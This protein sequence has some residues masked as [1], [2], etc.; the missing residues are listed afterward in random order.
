MRSRFVYFIKPIGMD[1]P[2]KIGCSD[3][4]VRRLL[5]LSVWSPF[6]LEVIAV[7]PGDLGT[8]KR[9]HE[10]FAAE[11]LH[12]EWFLPSPRLVE[13]CQRLKRNVPLT[14]AIPLQEAA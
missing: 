14:E 4:P 13:A 11:R 9:L 12:S 2:V 6:P 7:A 10:H 1:G 3:K 8:E 5:A